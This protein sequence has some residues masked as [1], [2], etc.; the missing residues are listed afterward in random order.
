MKANSHYINRFF[1]I[2]VFLF[3]G[4]CSAFASQKEV[5]DKIRFILETDQPQRKL[6]VRGLPLLTSSE[7]HTLYGAREF[8]PVWSFNGELTEFAYE[9]R[10]EI[11]QS[12][13]DGLNPEEYNLK[14]IQTYF[15][16]FESNKK[17][18][19]ANDFSD[20]ADFDLLLTDAFFKLVTHLEVGKVDPSSLKSNWGIEP[21]QKQLDY[22]E[23]LHTA[24][25]RKEIRPVIQSVYPKFEIYRKGREVVRNLESIAKND[26]LDWKPV[27]ENKSIKVGETNSAIPALRD[28]LIFWGYLVGSTVADKSS[29]LYDSLLF[30]AVKRYQ[31]DNGLEADGILGKMTLEALNQ[32]PK[33]L[34]DKAS[35]NLERLRWL[36]DTIQNSTYILVNIANFELDFIDNRDT[37]FSEKVIVGQPYHQSPVFSAQMSYIVFS[38]Y[39]NIPYSIMRNETLPAIRKNPSY[40]TRNNMEVITRSGKYVDPSTVDFSSKS[41]PYLIRQKPGQNNS[42]GL[43]KFMFPNKY[44]VYI[45]DTPTRNLFEKEERALSHGCIRLKNPTQL[46]QLL[47]KNNQDWDS[48]KI[49]KAMNQPREQIVNLDKKIP[50]ILVY[51]TFWADSNGKGHFRSDIYQRDSEILAALRS[52]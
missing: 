13:Y 6:E 31:A 34:I 17:K 44:S 42:L 39:W 41:F 19:N 4:V 7:I 51:L 37:L 48:Q 22:I 20:L 49:E 24:L 28:R 45:H 43:V 1:L 27:K 47:L 5:A 23:L 2:A 11:I 38:P 33:S 12:K 25:M 15:E 10:Y 21:I 29:K 9:M 26:S 40:L 52:F 3:S 46:A 30:E 50:V 18:K 14:L 32:S 16:A 8:N 36:P 35:V